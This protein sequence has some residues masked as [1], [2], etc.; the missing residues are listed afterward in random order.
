MKVCTK[1]GIEKELSEF[2]KSSSIS[3]YTK[4][5]KECKEEN[6][7]ILKKCIKCD[8]DKILSDFKT[9]GKSIDGRTNICKICSRINKEI[10]ICVNCKELKEMSFKFYK[11]N[12]LKIK[13]YTNKCIDCY[14][15][16]EQLRSINKNKNYRKNNIDKI[17]KRT[18]AYIKENKDKINKRS[19]E[20]Y[21]K[22]TTLQKLRLSISN[23]IKMSLKIK[24]LIKGLR[25]KDILGCSF[26]EFKIYIESK[27]EDWMTWENKGLYNGEYNHGW[28][29][30]H[31]IPISSAKTEEEVYKLNHYS[32]FQPLC[33]KI[34]RYD[35]KDR[36][37]Y[38]IKK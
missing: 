13:S 23:N 30:D 22:F 11:K 18:K 12:G 1:C 20:Y 25:T 9:S 7:K 28:D 38:I 15:K 6:S 36:L 33:S 26:E 19:R 24:K 4:I 27:F 10:Q 21:R 34:N 35:K 29:L 37:E 17:N 14:R 31:I 16:Q 8:T 5:C 32:N 3:G 2:N